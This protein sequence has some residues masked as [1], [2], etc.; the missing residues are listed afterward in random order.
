[1]TRE[2]LF[3]V[4]DGPSINAQLLGRICSMQTNSFRS[5]GNHMTVHMRTDGSVA[6]RGFNAT[7][8]TCKYKSKFL[9][10]SQ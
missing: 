6:Y 5:S 9:H 8:S 10:F 7:Y 1:M 4:Y 3:Q 2:G